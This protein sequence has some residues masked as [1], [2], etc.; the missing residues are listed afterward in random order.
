MHYFLPIVSFIRRARPLP[1]ALST[2]HCRSPF[3]PLTPHSSQNIRQ[4]PILSIQLSRKWISCAESLSGPWNTGQKGGDV[5]GHRLGVGRSQF[6]I[7][8]G[9]YVCWSERPA[10]CSFSWRRTIGYRDRV[11]PT[12]TVLPYSGTR[13]TRE[14][15]K[16][17][18]SIDLRLLPPLPELSVILAMR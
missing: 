3:S 12:P 18:S 10:V 8:S 13:A 16:Y 14:S 1:E 6:T 9:R 17:C 4:L 7:L 2:Q 15:A 11:C 5:I